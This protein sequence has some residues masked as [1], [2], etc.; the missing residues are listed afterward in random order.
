MS[1]ESQHP[2]FCLTLSVKTALD[3]A[4]LGVLSAKAGTMLGRWQNEMLLPLVMIRE[5]LGAMDGW[6]EHD[7]S[8]GQFRA[9]VRL[10]APPAGVTRSPSLKPTE[11]PVR[12]P[13]LLLP[14]PLLEGHCLH[15]VD[16]EFSSLASTPN[17]VNTLPDNYDSAV[18]GSTI[19]STM[20]S[21]SKADPVKTKKKV[22]RTKNKD[23]AFAPLFMGLRILLVDDIALNLKVMGRLLGRLG[24]VVTT[25]A[26]GLEAMACL[27]RSDLTIDLVLLDVD[28]P[29]LDGPGVLGQMQLQALTTPVIMLSGNIDASISQR[30]LNLGAKEF[31]LKPLRLPALAP[32]IEQFVP[33]GK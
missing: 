4:E 26:D 30:C 10:H 1:M 12:L 19:A 15:D 6:H 28:M 5:T 9:T 20:A 27:T 23:A 11:N 21:T 29:N 32:L 2:V 17:G 25:A 13:S 33:K 31:L 3:D 16:I 8:S 7:K 22:K 24:A 14:K 18:G